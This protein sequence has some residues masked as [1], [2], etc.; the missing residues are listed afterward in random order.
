VLAAIGV[1]VHVLGRLWLT[2][3]GRFF[4]TEDDGYRAYYGHL[5]A[6][7][8]ASVIGR[9]WLPG[10]FFVL[11]ALGRAGLD[12]ALAPMVLGVITFVVTLVAVHSL[13]R[14]LAPEGWGEAAGR[15]AVAIAG[16]SP[17]LLVLSHSA[18]AEPL[19][20]ALVA[21]AAAALVRR[22]RV[23]PRRLVWSGAIT[24]LLATWIRYETWAYALAFVAGAVVMAH[25]REGRRVA[26]GDG[27]IA[28]LALLGPL[29]WMLA[30]YVE[31][32][33]PFAFLDTIDEMATVLTGGASPTRVA[34]ARIEGL[35]LWAGG[36]VLAA[37]TAVVVLRR[38]RAALGPLLVVAAVGVPG[39][40][41]QIVTGK[42]L[43]VFVV[44]GREIEFFEPRLVSNVEVGLFPLAGLGVAMLAS[45]AARAQRLVLVGIALVALAL[46]ARGLSAP[47]QFVDPSSVQ[48]GLA[49]RRGELDDAVGPGALLVERVE[50]RPPM[51][52][53]S[54]SVQWS[55]WDRTLFFTRRGESCDVVEASDVTA[56]RHRMPCAELASWAERREVSAA[57]VLSE[58][59]RMLVEALWPGA[60]TRTIGAG[61]LVTLRHLG[62]R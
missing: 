25:R 40:L 19:A 22:H 24:M 35:T 51:G 45:S 61:Q 49:L 59:A 43:A 50:P 52:W 57:W 32:G 13:A 17:L 38:D 4:A 10:Q 23:G 1:A 48:A 12:A 36:A 15:G 8:S 28:S 39:L 54:L 11:G 21:F 30:Q 33:D 6:D 47:M 14:D 16:C 53:A 55:R 58:D 26:L 42:G 5:V 46:A 7:G 27:A 2:A 31:H 18:L 37:A 20:N 29:G 62:G 56:G 41:L 34:T 9:F 3:E 60:P 44:A